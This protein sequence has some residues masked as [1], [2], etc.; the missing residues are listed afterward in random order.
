MVALN[1][2]HFLSVDS[3]C[4]T[5]DKR[6]NGFVRGEGVGILILKHINDAIRD[7]DC[8]RA[9][10]RGTGV[11]QDGKTPGITLPSSEA[12][13]SL[14]QATYAAANLSPSDTSYFEAH[15]TGTQQG[16]AME[17]GAIAKVFDRTDPESLPLYLGSVKPNIGHLEGAAGVAGLIKAILTLERAVIPPN[18]NFEDPNPKL[19]LGDRNFKIPKE[20]SDWPTTGLRRASVNSFGYGGTNAHCIVDDPF[21]YL[22]E[23]GIYGHTRTADVASMPSPDQSDDDSGISLDDAIE[24]MRDRSLR[25]TLFVL[26]APDQAA[27]PRLA[28]L[29]AEH[30]T[31]VTPSN[32]KRREDLF[33]DLEYT[34]NSRRSF[35]QWR[36]SLI[37]NNISDLT[38]LLSNPLNPIRV[39]KASGV[40]FCFTG[41]GAQWFG[42]GRELMIY[43]V[44][45]ESVE[46]A[47]TYLTSELGASFSAIEELN[48]DEKSSRINKPEYSQPC[49]TI[50]QVALVDLLRHWGIR[51][52]IVVGHSSG[53]IASA[54]AYGALSAEECWKIGF[55][56]GR[57]CGQIRT[58]APHLDGAML[59]VGVEPKEVEPYIQKLC[60][61]ESDTLTIGCYNSPQNITMSGD[62]PLIEKLE[63]DLKANSVFCRRIMVDNAYHSA[64]I[65]VIADLFREAI[66]DIRPKEVTGDIVMFSS[67]T[68]GAV[69]WSDLDV[70]YWIGNT[71]SPASFTQALEAALIAAGR[72][73]GRK[74]AALKVPAVNAIVEIGPHGALQGPIRQI[75]E[76]VKKTESISYV[77]ALVRK[78]SAVESALSMAGALWCRG[79]NVALDLVNSIT[80]IPEPRIPLTDLPKYPW[81][82]EN[83]YWHES[84]LSESHRF[85]DS[86]RTDLL[87]APVTEFSSHDPVWK[88]IIRVSEQPWIMDHR[89]KDSILYPAAGM[90]CA[91]L[92]AA[93]YLSDKSRTVKGY[94]LRDVKVG[95][96]LV[97]PFSDPGIEVF[98]RLKP[99][100]EILPTDLSTSYDFSFS[101]L[102]GPSF[103]DR[104]F[105]EHGS[106]T[107][108]ICYEDAT[109]LRDINSDIELDDRKV[110]FQK[111]LSQ[112]SDLVTGEEHYKAMRDIG[113]E[114]G[115]TF[116]GLESART[117][118]GQAA[119]TIKIQDTKS[120]M[121]SNFEYPFLLH[122]VTLDAAMHSAI[123]GFGNQKRA[124]GGAMVPTA[125][126]KIAISANIPTSPGTELSGFVA[127]SRIGFKDAT[128]QVHLSTD[129]WPE[130]MIEI[131]NMTLTSLTDSSNRRE[132]DEQQATMRRI[133][134]SQVWKPDLDLI[135]TTLEEAQ[136]IFTQNI[137]S[138]E[139]ITKFATVSTK[140]AAIFIKRALMFI[141]PEIEHQ[142]SEHN[143]HLVKWMREKQLQAKAHQLDYQTEVDDW[144]NLSFEEEEL[145][146]QRAIDIIGAEGE[147][148]RVIGRNLP[149]II[150]E[151]LQSVELLLESG[152]LSRLYSEAIGLKSLT[153]MFQNWFDL[154]GHKSPG[155]KIIEIGAGTGSMT[156]P[157]LQILSKS[158]GSMPRLSSYCFTDISPS[159]FEKASET[160]EQWSSLMEYKR[161]NIENDPIDQGFAPESFDIIVA[162]NVLHATSRVDA[163]LK[164]CLKLLKP[165]GKIV[166]GE[167]TWKSD[168]IGFIFGTMPGWWLAGD[169]RQ[170]GPLLTRDE[171]KAK[172]LDVGFAVGQE[173]VSARDTFGNA[174]TSM[175]VAQKPLS[176]QASVSK[177]LIITP[178]NPSA[179]G[180]KLVGDIQE[181]YGGTSTSILLAT[182]EQASQ[183]IKDDAVWS[184]NNAVVSLLEAFDPVFTR[185]NQ[186]QFEAIQ[187]LV[188]GS[189]KLLWISCRVSPKGVQ[190]P[191]ACAISGLLRVARSENPEL[192]IHE[193]HL[194]KRELI[195]LQETAS[196]ITRVIDK[197]WVH[198]FTSEIESEIVE[199]DGKLQ[200]PRLF[201]NVPMNKALLALD[202]KV[203]P[204]LS[205]L[206][207]EN[208]P[209][210]LT[211]ETPGLLSSLHFI[212]DTVH[213]SDLLEDEVEIEVKASGL[214]IK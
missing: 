149:Y 11:N 157:V 12:Q 186:E 204:E 62:L 162:S 30:I 105:V 153:C 52:K 199:I 17:V 117:G 122:P 61:T 74:S 131:S 51:P 85:R 69:Q 150:C 63:A 213:E 40:V 36:T 95:R 154:Q 14:I 140:A 71:L 18:I 173:P 112:C 190:E 155:M 54:Y 127:S 170:G 27:L 56:R 93:K 103:Q 91:T 70:E 47:D 135:D 176:S 15:G 111:V 77:T 196:L 208:R 202:G 134:S 8:I 128:A 25:R 78:K 109:K 29:H 38:E 174:L 116:Q 203:H 104:N 166:I 198:P 188:I 145:T 92:E 195:E 49:C 182:L 151:I 115:P 212:D 106:G 28:R 197:L 129:G 80:R 113:I 66:A 139:K 148:L 147:A 21:H 81:N 44:Y 125:F 72:S 33:Q 193:L 152:L 83:T 179:F 144:L 143:S 79:F 68:A 137:P 207:Q 58:I 123:Q 172:L 192:S 194:R 99:Q 37:A 146:I 13:K 191:D 35:F 160:F 86:P 97:I 98:T 158:S 142:L 205:L 211:I 20:P 163:T 187:Q 67:V 164:N 210:K 138:A 189:P 132:V 185:C 110:T 102:E 46:R 90:L 171:W 119:V 34:Y 124:R 167:L 19:R 82:H 114:Y 200:I 89:V 9:V 32:S 39:A 161:L 107:V 73:T 136:Q 6:A 165:G 96:A 87:G 7:N 23:R 209:L 4:F 168:H 108:A 76:A 59:A 178:V 55:H 60:I 183:M 10:I 121:P 31:E 130:D 184:K 5:F 48:K 120:I 118:S 94:E 45:R 133:T 22:S 64:H 50:V 75:L 57:L 100:D 206:N 214:D 88:N 169:G 24:V 159:F 126:E 84:K 2:L 177:L 156:L 42:M 3:Q 26:S 65:K 181:H 101:S 43:N 16:D 1:P 175:I 180:D 53:E 201:D 41:Q 141:T